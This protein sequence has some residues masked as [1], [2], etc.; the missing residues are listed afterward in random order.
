MGVTLYI[1]R[2]PMEDKKMSNTKI[3]SDWFRHVEPAGIVSFPIFWGVLPTLGFAPKLVSAY[4]PPALVPFATQ[5]QEKFQLVFVGTLVV[6]MFELFYAMYRCGRLN[7]NPTTTLKWFAN[8]ALNGIFALK[9]L[10]NPDEFYQPAKSKKK[11]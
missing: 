3:P 7:L 11:N 8:V 2:S 5:H 1:P 10:H 9:M 6:H 4:A